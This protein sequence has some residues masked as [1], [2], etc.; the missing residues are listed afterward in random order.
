MSASSR[1]KGRAG[2]REAMGMLQNLVTP[3]YRVAGLQVPVIE[4]NY[5]QAAKGGTDLLNVPLLAV[6]VK[7]CE[8]RSPGAWW[9]QACA[10]ADD[11]GLEPCVVYRAN[12]KPWRV[13]VEA[14]TCGGERELFDTTWEDFARWYGERLQV[15]VQALREGD[16]E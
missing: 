7:R 1:R 12:R 10:A 14:E 8:Q 2:E 9:A 6:E 11:L 15:H 4:L 3:L 13:M 5:A 16:S